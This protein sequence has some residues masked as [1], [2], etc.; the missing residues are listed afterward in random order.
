MVLL[1]HTHLHTP[2]GH[3]SGTDRMVWIKELLTRN[4]KTSMLME[5]R[6]VVEPKGIILRRKLEISPA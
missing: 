5:R 1:P 6:N 3:N 2:F 4:E